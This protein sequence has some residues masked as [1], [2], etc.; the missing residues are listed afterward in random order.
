MRYYGVVDY[1]EAL[2]CC[3]VVEYSG[4]VKG[5]SVAAFSTMV[6]CLRPELCCTV[7]EYS[8]VYVLE[9]VTLY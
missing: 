7:V 6:L 5:S 2:A 9:I 8:R 4:V 3:R 1:T